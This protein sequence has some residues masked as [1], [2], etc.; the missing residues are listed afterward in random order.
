MARATGGYGGEKGRLALA[1][2]SLRQRERDRKVTSGSKP[3]AA[4]SPE[5]VKIKEH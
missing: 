4:L 5:N 3:N 1:S 2:V